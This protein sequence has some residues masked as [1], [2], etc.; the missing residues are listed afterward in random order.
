MID[1]PESRSCGN[2][3][4][5]AHMLPDGTILE[6]GNTNPEGQ[7]VCQRNPPGGRW[8]RVEVPSFDAKTGAPITGR[9]GQQRTEP[10]QVLQIGYPPAVETGVCFDGWRPV[11]TRPGE[12]YK[13]ANVERVLLPICGQL[14]VG[15][16]QAAK[17]LAE[18][19]LA[20]LLRESPPASGTPS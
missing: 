1:Q 18:G 3:A 15:N 12:N 13:L 6:R 8:T 9:N 17:R 19:M 10:R 5:F 14:A 4:C 20:D 2:C 7:T 16:T 11:G